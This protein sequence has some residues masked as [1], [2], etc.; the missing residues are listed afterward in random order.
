MLRVS[1]SVTS[2]F[3]AL[4]TTSLQLDRI[5]YATNFICPRPAGAANARLNARGNKT[6][7]RRQLDHIKCKA[8]LTNNITGSIKSK[9]DKTIRERES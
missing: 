8:C 1:P 4:P 9:I 6:A 5:V 3:A 7:N 2:G